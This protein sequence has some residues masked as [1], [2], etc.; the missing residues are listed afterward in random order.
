[1]WD[2]FHFAPVLLDIAGGSIRIS[3]DL[4]QI[5]ALMKKCLASVTYGNVAS[6][7]DSD[8]NKPLPLTFPPMVSPSHL[9][10]TSS[11]VIK[12]RNRCHCLPNYD[13]YN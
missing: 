11:K 7:L 2:I 9:Y 13:T 6:G 1:M 5:H 8:E 10:T 3:L 4:L 12:K